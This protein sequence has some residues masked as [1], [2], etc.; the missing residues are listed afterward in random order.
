VSR[1][2]SMYIIRQGPY[3]RDTYDNDI[4]PPSTTIR[5]VLYRI[6]FSGI[7]SKTIGFVDRI[8]QRQEYTIEVSARV[9]RRRS[10]CV[11]KPKNLV[12]IFLR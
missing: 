3:L 1:Y 7:Y 2:D 8:F 11:R 4:E 9:D 12:S 5:T 6:E 10:I